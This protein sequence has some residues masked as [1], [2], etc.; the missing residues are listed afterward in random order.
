MNA[1]EFRESLPIGEGS[2]FGQK[3]VIGLMELYHS[4]KLKELRD[5]L[6]DNQ[7]MRIIFDHI[8]KEHERTRA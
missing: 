6:G 3:E 1:R 7:G 4:Y 2:F 8:I 5:T